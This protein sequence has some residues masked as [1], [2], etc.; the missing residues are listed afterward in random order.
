MT[1]LRSSAV[2]TTT[3]L[4]GPWMGR[5]P[6]R[7]VVPVA[8][9]ASRLWPASLA[10]PKALFPLVDGNGVARTVLDLVLHELAA[11][12]IDEVCLVTAPGDDVIYRR[13]LDR[14]GEAGFG[15]G[16]PSVAF[17]TQPTP[18][19]YGHAVWCAAHW[20]GDDPVLVM[21]GDTVYLSESARP[22]A[23]QVA[24]AFARLGVSTSGVLVTPEAEIGGYGTVAA[25]SV[26]SSPGDFVATLVVEKPSVEV[27]RASLRA[28]GLADGT[29]LTWFGIHAVS[30]AIF[31][32]LDEDVRLGRRDRGEYQFTGAQARLVDREGLAVTLIDGD[33]LDTGNPAAWRATMAALRARPTP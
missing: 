27:A 32:V 23:A 24:D 26:P 20:V 7:A 28:E 12:G 16:R 31:D 33:R 22:C 15:E 18:E 1:T 2:R 6:H 19:G 21:L 9:R 14:S 3:S 11:S 10:V 8:G 4:P 13:Y 25:T 5:R 30:P 29:Y 17:V